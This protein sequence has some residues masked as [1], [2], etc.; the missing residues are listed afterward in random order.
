[1]RCQG[2]CTTM[3]TIEKTDGARKYFPQEPK[4]VPS[5]WKTGSSYYG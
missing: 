5:L 3:A 2:T 4:L 1:M